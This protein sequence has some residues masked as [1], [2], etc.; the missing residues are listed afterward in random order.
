MECGDNAA[1]WHCGLHVSSH[2]SARRH[3][4]LEFMAHANKCVCH[5]DDNLAGKKPNVFL[6]RCGSAFP[7]GCKNNDI[8]R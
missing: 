7:R 5:A 4:W 3:Q 6:G 8:T 2:T 1:L